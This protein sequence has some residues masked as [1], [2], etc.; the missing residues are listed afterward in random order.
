MVACSLAVLSG[1]ARA[2]GRAGRE[3]LKKARVLAT[4]RIDG[5]TPGIALVNLAI[6]EVVFHDGTRGRYSPSTS[7]EPAS[8][9]IITPTLARAEGSGRIAPEEAS[10]TRYYRVDRGKVR[11]AW[12]YTRFPDG[13]VLHTFFGRELVRKRTDDRQERRQARAADGRFGSIRISE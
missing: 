9:E 7:V 10:T 2:G 6:P 5:K 1:A 12:T 13:G 8:I 4:G 3:A 11:H